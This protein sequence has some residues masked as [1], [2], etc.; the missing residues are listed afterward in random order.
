MPVI[1]DDLIPTSV[2]TDLFD[3]AA[4]QSVVLSLARRQ[5]MPTAH[6]IVPV[7]QTLPA[8]GWV[9]GR[10]GRKPITNIEWSAIHLTPEEVAA[11]IAIPQAYIDDSGLPI[12]TAVRDRLA[13]AIAYS[14]D[15]AVLFGV[16]A[17]PSFPAGGVVAEAADAF[18]DADYSIAV[19]NAM[20]SVEDQGVAVTGHGAD[21]SVR[22]TLRLLRNAQGDPIFIG[23]IAGGAMPTTLYG[24]PIAFSANGAFDTSVADLITGNW[25]ML[26]VGVRQD[27]SFDMSEDAVLTDD[28]GNVVANAF[29]DDL[30]VMRVHMRLGVVVGS[31][32]TRA[33]GG[34]VYPFALVTKTAPA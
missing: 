8:T 24:V 6:S 20:S 23:N 15:S 11:V 10:G 26:V 2:V 3:Q 17:P 9:N 27:M 12:W 19:S 4:T 31:P 32:V 1:P 28:E 33:A 16:D 29:Q 25:D 30:V 14:I 22:G 7:I 34:P 18:Y 5:P 21:I 13:E